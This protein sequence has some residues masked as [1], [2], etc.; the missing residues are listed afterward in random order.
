M[1]RTQIRFGTD[2]WRAIIAEDYTFENVRSCAEGVARYLEQTGLASRGLV[3]GFDT[4]F[5]SEHFAAASAE[6][7]AA[8]G[9]K[10]Y[11]F[12]AA[13]ATPVACHA[14]LDKKAGGAI[15]ITASH[16]PGTYNGFKYK[17]EYAGSAPPEVVEALEAN[18]DAS[19]GEAAPP[20]LPL[21][22]AIAEGLVERFDPR[23]AYDHHVAATLDLDRI[24]SAGL[25]IAYDAMHATGAGVLARLLEG[26]V[27][28]V[29]E[30]RTERNPIFPGMVAPEPIARNLAVLSE[31]VLN[32]DADV[33]LA[34][35]G[36]AD[37]LGIVD[38][39]GVF[40]D[41]LQTFALLCYYLLEYRGDRGPLVRSL[42]S[43]RMIDKLGAAYGVPVYETPVGFKFLGPKMMETGA[44]AAGEESGGYSFGRHL[45]ERDGCYA[46]LLF[47]DLLARAGKTPSELVEELYAKVGEHFYDRLDVHL[48]PSQ[49]QGAI[50]RVASATPE[51]LAGRRVLRK[52][53][54]DGFRF[55]TDAGWLLI[56]PSGTEPLLRIYTE[57]TDKALVQPILAAGRELAGV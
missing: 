39:K 38:E 9:I 10:T 56:R 26:G 7:I 33:G 46:G 55:E 48:Q 50:E 16:N 18:I 6:V 15:I 49:R 47:L 14:I 8:H 52:D 45:P 37:R 29:H 57:T 27:T 2:G 42:T 4:R 1:T 43:T 36:D 22:Q 24:R 13:A 34:T 35:D 28:R 53:D 32:T 44:I 31:T 40:I 41:Q 17:P 3:I 20:R 30:L 12:D 23:P 51:A 5:G 11:L 19:Q 21:D 25:N 54:I